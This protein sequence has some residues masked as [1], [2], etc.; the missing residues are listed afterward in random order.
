MCGGNVHHKRRRPLCQ[1]LSP[2]VRGKQARGGG[3]GVMVR[4]IPACAGE[5]A[6]RR[7]SLRS[8]AVY[9][10]VCGGNYLR[11]HELPHPEG[12]S[13]RVRG[14]PWQLCQAGAGPRSIPACAGETRG[15]PRQRRPS[16]VYPRVC[17]GNRGPAPCRA[18]RRGLSPR[19]RGKRQPAL[20]PGAILRSIPACAGET[21]GGGSG[22]ATNRVY[23]RVCG[24]NNWRWHCN[25]C[26]QGLSPRVRGKLLDDVIDAAD[27]GSIP[28]CAGETAVGQRHIPRRR[29]YPRV[30]GGNSYTGGRW[31]QEWGLSPRVRGKL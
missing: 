28:A 12:L 11:E 8:P 19:V 10:R 22:D 16:G 4:S 31:R 7:H 29:V 30:C 3:G 9:P 18:Y 1:G 20:R 14:K 21:T 17:G 2:R 24:G 13:P 5:T 26:Y 27:R 15:R 23:P 25:R 6:P